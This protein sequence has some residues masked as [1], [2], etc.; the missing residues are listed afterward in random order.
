MRRITALL[1]A[2][3][4]VLGGVGLMTRQTPDAP[5]DDA[6]IALGA[7]G[8]VEFLPPDLPLLPEPRPLL[9]ETGPAGP[10]LDRTFDLEIQR[11]QTMYQALALAGVAHQ[12]I[13][14]LVGQ[15]RS[16]RDLR[17]VRVGER[18]A[19]EVSADGQLLAFGFDLDI[20]SWVR[21][22]RHQDG[23]AFEQVLGSY[24]VERRVVGIHGEITTS[25]YAALQACGAP[26]DIAAKMSDILGWDIDFSRDPRQG[27][28][29]R[30]I[31]EE[32]YKD[33]AFVRTGAILTCDYHGANR[34]L[35]AHRFTLANGTVGY[36]DGEG[37]SMQKQLMRAP[38]NYSRV[39]SGF[40][41]NRRHPVL[42]R[43]M[44]HLG[45]DYAAPVGTPV[46]AAG[47]GA[48]IAMGNDKANGRYVQ[49]RH[50]NREY[51]TYYLHFS[52]FARGLKVGQRVRQGEVIG[53]VGATGYA[54][55]PHLDFR[56]KR[57]GR[58]VNPATLKLPPASP[59]PADEMAAFRDARLAHD[60]ARAELFDV[61]ASPRP[62]LALRETPPWRDP[63]LQAG[64][65][66][67]LSVPLFDL[68]A[69][70]AGVVAGH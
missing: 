62:V 25:L 13:M 23:G 56:I 38:L 63:W 35:V 15:V 59:V 1:L 8:P 37:R 26:L 18:F 21:Y 53:Y 30:V 39:S 5:V 47:D 60:L 54:T 43:N 42:G 31:F 51:E 27:D 49:I 69:V 67:P 44:P 7:G 50:N 12:D 58:F 55:G 64:L 40:S 52:R 28:T 33:G 57:G 65:V 6:E 70:E 46:W 41:Y 61:A 48:V 19:L 45:I 29:F 9:V 32:I 68:S 11:G 17:K 4:L 34:E 20:E 10:A 24:P 22:E 2:L 16:F 14:D 66:P 36:F 3:L